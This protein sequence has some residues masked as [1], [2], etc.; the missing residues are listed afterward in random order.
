MLNPRCEEIIFPGL[1]IIIDYTL[2]KKHKIRV[3]YLIEL[4]PFL[5][6]ILQVLPP[7]TSK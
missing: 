7:E 4:F 3:R 2:A 6:T 1:P 5:E